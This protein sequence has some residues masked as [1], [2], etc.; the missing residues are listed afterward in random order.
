MYAPTPLS[1]AILV[2]WQWQVETQLTLSI[3]FKIGPYEE[4]IECDIVLVTVRHMLHVRPW[5]YDRK[6]NHGGYIN[7]YSF[8]VNKRMFA[9]HPRTPSQIIADNSKALASAREEK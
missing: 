2:E 6:A 7:V 1:F 5:Q 4:T 8:K 3:S 9:L